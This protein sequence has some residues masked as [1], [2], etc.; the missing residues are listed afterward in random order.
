MTF[1][2]MYALFS[3]TLLAGRDEAVVGAMSL[4][5]YLIEGTPLARKRP[6]KDTGDMRGIEEWWQLRDD[7]DDDDN[8]N[9]FIGIC[10]E[11]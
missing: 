1:T 11:T 5:S 9:V 4:F 7:D 3:Q 10:A 2:Q 8:D 6:V